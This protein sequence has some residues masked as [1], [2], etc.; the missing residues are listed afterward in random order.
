MFRGHQG[1][2]DLDAL[3]GDYDIVDAR[4]RNGLHIGRLV[5]QLKGGPLSFIDLSELTNTIRVVADKYQ[6]HTLTGIQYA[7]ANYRV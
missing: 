3:P 7:T 5:T 4:G 6:Q 2:A 1:N